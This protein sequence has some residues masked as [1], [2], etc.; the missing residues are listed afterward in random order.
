MSNE[1]RSVTVE[2]DAYLLDRMIELAS[3][4]YDRHDDYLKQSRTP[5]Y[6][7]RHNNMRNAAGELLNALK[8]AQRKDRVFQAR[9]LFWE[10]NPHMTMG[11]ISER[12]PLEPVA[13]QR[14]ESPE[15]MHVWQSGE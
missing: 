2:V 12:L 4:A 11:E 5:E 15:P 1:L 13:T 8:E 10:S 6:K 3:E 14:D 9:S 7:L